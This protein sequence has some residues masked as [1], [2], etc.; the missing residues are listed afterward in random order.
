MTEK[1][2]IS[3]LEK[4]QTQRKALHHGKIT[5]RRGAFYF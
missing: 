2:E 5:H 3:F 4:I 1:N